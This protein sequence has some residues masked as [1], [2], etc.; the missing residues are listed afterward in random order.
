MGFSLFSE[1][2]QSERAMVR[3]CAPREFMMPQGLLG[4]IRIFRLAD[5]TGLAKGRP[6][7]AAFRARASIGRA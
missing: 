7:E 2:E 3:N 4:G 1:R 6:W 5:E